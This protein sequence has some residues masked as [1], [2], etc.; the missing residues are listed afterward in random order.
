MNKMRTL[1]LLLLLF[2][3]QSICNTGNLQ[4]DWAFDLKKKERKKVIEMK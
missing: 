1:L 4:N 3:P 2:L